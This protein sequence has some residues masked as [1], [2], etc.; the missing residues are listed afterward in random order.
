MKQKELLAKI[1][2][3]NSKIDDIKVKAVEQNEKL[4]LDTVKRQMR[5]G[6]KGDGTLMM[7]YSSVYADYKVELPTYQ[8]PYPTPDLY[9]DGDFQ[10]GM[11]LNIVGKEYIIDSTDDKTEYLTDHYGDEIMDLTEENIE[12]KIKP[13]VTS[14]FVKEYKKEI[15]L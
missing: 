1:R 9:H 3:A 15:G 5:A 6:L 14:D 8:A 10:D 7:D 12:N 2:A 11:V 4:I 13:K